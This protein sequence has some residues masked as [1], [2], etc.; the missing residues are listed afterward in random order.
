M[1]KQDSSGNIGPFQLF[2][3]GAQL[4]AQ[5]STNGSSWT[6]TIAAAGTLVAN[7]LYH[8][9]LV[10][11][12]AT[13]TLY[14][15]GSS[16]GSVSIG[17]GVALVSN[18][19]QLYIGGYSSGGVYFAG[20][21]DEWRMVNGAATYTGNFTPPAAPFPDGSPPT[22]AARSLG[23][24]LRPAYRLPSPTRTQLRTYLF[25]FLRVRDTIW[26]GTGKI[27]GVTTINNTP[28]S[29]KVRLFDAR[30]GLLIR[31]TWADANGNYVF[32]NIDP[33]RLYFVVGHDYQM[34]YNAVVQDRITPDPMP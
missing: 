8:V 5:F 2:R 19:T 26:G 13:A 9:A 31:Q 7:T 17:A 30:S 24:Y 10:R 22:Q 20:Y 18:T 28:G 16:I 11:Q 15:N 21:L 33:S 27:G 14:L 6:Q 4:S 29:R 3:T 32:P 34:V 12:G 1:H 23:R 25:P